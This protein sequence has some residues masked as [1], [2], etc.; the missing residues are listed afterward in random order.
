MGFLLGLVIGALAGFV[1]YPVGVALIKRL[2]G[3]VEE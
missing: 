1:M 2:T 3:R